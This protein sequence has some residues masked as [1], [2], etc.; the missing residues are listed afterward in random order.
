[1]NERLDPLR[2]F[3]RSFCLQVLSVLEMLPTPKQGGYTASF[4]RIFQ[5]FQNQSS[6]K[7][8][9]MTALMIFSWIFWLNYKYL[10]FLTTTRTYVRM[11][12]CRSYFQE[13]FQLELS[14]YD[15]LPFLFSSELKTFRN[16]RL[17][18]I[19]MTTKV[20]LEYTILF[21]RLLSSLRGRREGRRRKTEE[22]YIASN[23]HSNII[24][25]LSEIIFLLCRRR[26]PTGVPTLLPHLYLRVAL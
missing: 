1:M 20:L 4:N 10:A 26:Y 9:F 13:D 19:W 11:Y 17:W 18:R 14:F 21:V 16:Q 25:W 5:L 2:S 3:V 12:V 8:T 24:R 23:E 22:K 7:G 6:W 15:S